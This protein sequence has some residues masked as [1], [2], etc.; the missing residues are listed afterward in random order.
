M[1]TQKKTQKI[2]L[3]NEFEALVEVMHRLRRDCP[4]DREQ[5]LESLR[6]YLIEETYEVLEALN[7]YIDDQNAVN[8]KH[9]REELG[10]LL[11]QILFQAEIL[12]EKTNVDELRLM[13]RDL[14]D[15]LVRRHP[16]IFENSAEN[17]SAK[18]VHDQW[19]LIKAKEKAASKGPELQGSFANLPKGLPAT[20]L[21]QKIGEKSAKVRFDW[22][23]A[24]EAWLDVESEIQELKT[25]TSKRHQEEEFGDLL[26]SLIQWG[27][28]EKIDSEVALQRAN[29][30]FLSRF[31]SM[32]EVLRN[33]QPLVKMDELTYDQK[34]DLWKRVKKLEKK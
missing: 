17:L 5:T 25:A 21:G 8:L 2:T 13:M 16:H 3:M 1:D 15:K 19:N 20:L 23:S 18:E 29:E 26:F 28:H 22:N 33:E 9:L 14:R 4:W 12:N 10:D 27:R 34:N 32:E 31:T 11:L 6:K 30:K 7:H 24:P